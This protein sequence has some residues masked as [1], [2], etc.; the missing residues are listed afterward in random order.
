M[1][2]LCC[3]GISL[4]CILANTIPAENVVTPAPTVQEGIAWFDTTAW[5]IEGKGWEK[6]HTHFTRLPD[7]AQGVVP[8]PVWNLSLQSAGLV[9]RFKTDAPEVHARHTVSGNLTMPHMTTVGS[10]GLDL[11]AKD[12][13]GVWRWAGFSKPDAKEYNQA[14]LKGAS[15]ELREYLLY[16][17][18]YNK[19]ESLWVGVP[20]GCF[21]E[22]MP[23][24]EVK[25][26][27][28][29]GTSIAHG[30]SASRPGMAFP[31]ILGRRLHRPVINLGFSGNGRMEAEMA[32]L[33]AEIDAAVYAVDCLPNMTYDHVVERAET[34]I[35]KLRAARPDRPIVLV[36]DRTLSN[37][38]L[39]PW[40]QENHKKKR[41]AFRT[42]YEKL[43]AE[44]M[45]G[46]SYLEGEHLLG[47]DDEGT[48][49]SSHP[50]DLGMV[51]M[52]DAVEPFL[53]EA[54]E[55]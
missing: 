40:W 34:F 31:A 35:R 2:K 10:S 3:L 8:D 12:E 13:K 27:V 20:E 55:K 49:D 21:F 38:R 36:E 26:I 45:T 22:T 18:L 47:D 29:Y 19:T 42:V 1:R 7:S 39:L 5:G 30:C 53:W 11:Y 24:S 37:A 25:P 16:L 33:I 28:Y 43:T 46:L 17:P 23:P 50:T 4:V 48:V 14:L 54:L 6:T 51:R 32:D 15:P 52:A 41:E 9:V 44:G